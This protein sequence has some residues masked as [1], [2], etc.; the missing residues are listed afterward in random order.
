MCVI[1]KVK[2]LYKGNYIQGTNPW[3]KISSFSFAYYIRKMSITCFYH[4]LL[5][6]IL[7]F[8]VAVL[9]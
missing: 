7:S 9:W 2:V 5:K 8:R 1:F 4:L 6:L 3:L